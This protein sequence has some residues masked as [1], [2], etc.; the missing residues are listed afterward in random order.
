M[1]KRPHIFIVDDDPGARETTQMLL[2][3]EGYEMSC[4]TNGLE[5]LTQLHGFEPDVILLDVMM[6]EMDGFEVCQRL[7]TVSAWQHI[8]I[9]LVTALDGK[10]HLAKG[11]EVGADDFVSKPLNKLELRARVRSM[12]RIKQRHDEMVRML[13]LREDLSRMLIH[14]IRTPLTAMLMYCDLMEKDPLTSFQQRSLTTLRNQA[15]R[16]NTFAT[17]MLLMAKMEYGKM[18]LQEV[19]VDMRDLLA[20]AY[21]S[22]LSLA[23]THDLNLVLDVPDENLRVFLDANLW[24]RLLDNLVSNAI[25]YSYAG[26]TVTIRATTGGKKEARQ[27]VNLQIMDEGPGIPPEYWETIFDKFEVVTAVRQNVTQV[28]LGLA[29]CKLVVDAHQ[30]RIFVSANE[31]HGAIINIEV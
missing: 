4:A 20:A 9:I 27:R 26:G 30:G 8:P 13:E 2:L 19:W 11:L 28:G 25:K 6:P 24:Q 29:F 21:H 16:L 18:L 3:S 22:Y 1:M 17:D 7:K 15:F 10:E 5:A 14:D 31:P 23:Q 12:L